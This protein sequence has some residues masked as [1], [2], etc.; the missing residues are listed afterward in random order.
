MIFEESES[1]DHKS[2]ALI[3]NLSILFLKE[4]LLKTKNQLLPGL[5]NRT[6]DEDLNQNIFLKQ[7]KDFYL[8]KGTDQSFEI[9]FKALYNK[10]VEVI[11]PSEFLF[12]PSN[13]RYEIVNQLIVEPIEGDPDN[14]DGATL[15]QD[16]YK[17][18]KNINRS[19]APITSVE[20]IE[21]GY[22]K[23][24]YK[25]NFDGGYNRD[26]G[27]EG[28]QYGQFNVEPSTKIIGAVSSGSTIVDVDSTVGF[29]TT[30]ELYVTYTDT[31][32]GVVSYTS[33]SL[34]QFFGITNLSKNIADTTT[35]GINTFAYGRSK[36]DQDEI[37]KV[38]VSSVY[39]SIEIPENTTSLKK[40]TTANV[41]T[42]GF[43]EDNLKTG[44]WEYN[45][46]PC[47]SVEK[48][49]L[50][51][52]S[53]STYS[54]TLES[55]HYLKM[56]NSITIILKN[57]NRLDSNVI[58]IDNEKSFRVRGQGVLD[59]NGVSHVQRKIQK[60][61]STTF[62][63]ISDFSTGVD[64]VYKN[65][66]DDYIVAA[67]SLPSYNAQPIEI[68]QRKITFS[69]TFSGTEFEITP[70]VEHGYY[71]GEAIYYAASTSDE[72]FVDSDGSVKTRK[73]RNDG[74]FADG[75]YFVERVD[76]F[77]LKF[78]KSRDNIDNGKYVSV[79]SAVTVT[80]SS[81]QPYEFF[82][83]T[84]KPQ[85]LVRKIS[86]PKEQGTKTST[87]PGSTGILVNGVEILN[88]KSKDVIKYGPIQSIDVL[89]P[90]NNID[91]INVPNLIISDTVGTG[92][93]GHIAVSGSLREV[94]VLDGGFDYLHTPTLK[95][96][97]GNGQG[98]FGTVNMKLINHAPKFFADEASA[99]VSLTNDTIGFS[100]FHKF[101]NAEQVQY[102]TFDEECVVGLD[103]SALYFLSVVN[104]TTV[105][106][107]PTQ[108][109]AISGINTISLTGFGVGKHA[110]Q[111][112]NKKSVVSSI[113]VVNGGSGYETKKRTAPITGINTSSNIITIS[114][115][116][117]KSGE[118]VKYSVV[119][120]VAEGLTDNTEYYVTTID[121][122]SF[123]LSAV[124]VSSD[125]EFFYRTNQYVD[126]N[127]VGVGTHTFQLSSNH[128]NFSR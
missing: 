80:D 46:S 123:R 94:R 108:A 6:L 75:L 54:I 87:K 62:S 89:V 125:K 37:I 44:K 107:H 63:D 18:D 84:L 73:K 110:L 124:G 31:T 48:V 116:D 103:T 120:T 65:S 71:T 86:L 98:A 95:I 114:N 61:E 11:R 40:G 64:N 82:S 4:F 12:T 106:L 5:E 127:S 122:D 19:Y 49:E 1:D 83:K 29:G 88:Y 45:V 3:E 22:G 101:R 97:G 111:T 16:S 14:L 55:R 47:Y 10:D 59:I 70:G 56:G 36:L 38:R 2:G 58:G 99:K 60:G 74:L 25:L 28:T 43:D 50:L 85:K 8:S 118:K 91:V 69:G 109:D 27:V 96:D 9:L 76:G 81:I 35:V 102:Q 119:G 21:V 32:T 24:Y 39:N 68:K 53:D 17:F 128:S 66:N 26:I 41:T 34:T 20:K 105:R 15:Y 13:A 33:K 51:D 67:P 7:S 126:I 57:E 104:N 112:V 79:D 117:Y 72:Q 121:K 30:G 115:H 78:A 42:Y 113:T 92:A 52:S 100:T 23:T 93:T 90:T 77:T